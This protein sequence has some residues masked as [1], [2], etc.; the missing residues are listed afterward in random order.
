MNRSDPPR[1]SDPSSDESA[2]IRELLAAAE[3]PRD[4]TAGDHLRLKARVDAIASS[5][6]IGKWLWAKYGGLVVGVAAAAITARELSRP[7]RAQP[8]PIPS[9]PSAIAA[10]VETPRVPE[11]T[12]AA[13]APATIAPSARAN[14]SQAQ[15]AA[16]DATPAVR[17]EPA[18]APVARNAQTTTPRSNDADSLVRESALLEQARAVVRTDPRRTVE[19]L[20]EYDRAFSR[21][22]LRDERA[23]LEVDALFRLGYRSAARDLGQRV[24][25]AYPNSLVAERTRALLREHEE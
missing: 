22:S 11:Q 23:F 5:P 2:E 24:L 6:P 14:V 16:E 9:R 19:L 12:P 4:L 21:G 13:H 25:R 7:P 3:A 20:H 10:P 15:P 8:E 17:Q 18:R 1:M